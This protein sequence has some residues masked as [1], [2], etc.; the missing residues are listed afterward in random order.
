MVSGGSNMQQQ[1]SFE[2]VAALVDKLSSLDKLRL[3]ERVTST[4]KR[5]VL[6]DATVTPQ[7]DWATFLER[8]AGI[9]ADDPIKRW[10]QG[11]YEERDE[12]E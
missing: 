12:I 1:T 11:E 5:D 4:L 2:E 7:E 3:I 10:P 6:Q 9:L 8:T